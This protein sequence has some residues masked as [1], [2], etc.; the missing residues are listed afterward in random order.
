VRLGRP[1]SLPDDVAERVYDLWACGA[2]LAATVDQVNTEAAPTARG[3][4]RWHPGYRSGRDQPLGLA[5]NAWAW[6][7]SSVVTVMPEQ[8]QRRMDR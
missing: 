3:G 2:T 7:P 8:P 6:P 5:F 1:R 4:R